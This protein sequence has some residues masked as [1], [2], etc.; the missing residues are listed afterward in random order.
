VRKPAFENGGG[1]VTKYR[2]DG[3]FRKKGDKWGGRPVGE[4]IIGNYGT[5]RACNGGKK[6]KGKTKNNQQQKGGKRRRFTH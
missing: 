4:G 5:W 1:T 2:K 3:N 6:I